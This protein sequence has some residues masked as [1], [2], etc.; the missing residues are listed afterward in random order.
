MYSCRHTAVFSIS[1]HRFDCTSI[2]DQALRKNKKKR[3]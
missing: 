1:S 3:K 2:E